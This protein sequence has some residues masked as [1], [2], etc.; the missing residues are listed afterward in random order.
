[1]RIMQSVY[2]STKSMPTGVQA[3]YSLL[4]LSLPLLLYT[5]SFF[6]FLLLFLP[7]SSPPTLSSLLCYYCWCV[8][9][10]TSTATYL[11]T[12]G[13]LLGSS[14]LFQETS[15]LLRICTTNRGWVFPAYMH[16]QT[17]TYAHILPLDICIF[18]LLS[19]FTEGVYNHVVGTCLVPKLLVQYKTFK[20]HLCNG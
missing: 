7:S 15:E 9:T 14:H 10:T 11:W 19:V 6:Y 4:P 18:I 2:F 3:A 13:E 20:L 17:Q 5:T 1:M 8:S 12:G 16:T